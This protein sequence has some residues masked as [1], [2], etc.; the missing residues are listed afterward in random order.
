VS[1]PAQKRVKG[2]VGTSPLLFA[3]HET[4]RNLLGNGLLALLSYPEQWAILISQPSL[5]R[6]AVRELLRYDSPVQFIRRRVCEDMAL[7]GAQIQAGQDIV[8]LVASAN[9]DPEQFTDPERLDIRRREKA[10]LA[11]GCG[12]HMC[13]G[14]R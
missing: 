7:H 14:L 11:F 5:V 12:P 2:T 4:T 1:S 6:D 10:H 13:V 8:S 3:G 9:R